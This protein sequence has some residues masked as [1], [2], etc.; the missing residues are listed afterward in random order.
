MI[1]LALKPKK[2]YEKIRIYAKNLRFYA[3]IERI[4]AAK[5]TAI[6]QT[7]K[8]LGFANF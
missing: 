3:F 1:Q 6:K 2:R 5:H 8:F 7:N 4:L